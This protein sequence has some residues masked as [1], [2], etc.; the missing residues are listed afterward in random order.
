MEPDWFWHR[1]LD[2]F[3]S[4]TAESILADAVAR[5]GESMSLK[6]AAFF[7]EDPTTDFEPND[8]EREND[9]LASF[10]FDGESLRCSAEE[11]R[12]P[13][14]LLDDLVACTSLSEIGDSLRDLPNGEWVWVNAY[15]GINCRLDSSG[16][17]PDT[18]TAAMLWE[19]LLEPFW[20]WFQ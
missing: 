6:F 8:K 5:S 18:W 16:S 2:D 17:I 10:G 15:I 3:S 4:G 1:F 11:S 12:T 19:R 7:W 13:C 9:D 20:P 14:S